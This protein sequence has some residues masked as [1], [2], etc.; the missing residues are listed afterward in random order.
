MP[1]FILSTCG[2]SLFTNGISNEL[3]S[4][5]FQYANK[6]DWSEIPQD[7]VLRL[8]QYAELQKQKLLQAD[9]SL[10]KK[11]SAELNSLLSWQKDQRF[12]Q[13]DMRVLLAT[14]TVL[15]QTTA[16]MIQEWL[17]AQG[18]NAV[19]MSASGL[20]TASLQS[21]RESLSELTANLIEQVT[22]FKENGYH[23]I[24]N[25]AGGFKSLNGFLQAFSTIY[26]DETF[27]IFESSSEVLSIPKLPFRLDA[28]QI[29]KENLH[30]FRRLAYQLPVNKT[31]AYAIP[32]TLLFSIGSD[33]ILSEW[34]ELL[35]QSS[36]KDLYKTQ[37]LPSISERIVFDKLF[38][39][40]TKQLDPLILK[41]VN[42]RIAELTVYVEGD[43][44]SALK[45]VDP[46][47][48]QEKQCKV[49]NLWECDLD[50]HHRIFMVKDGYTFTLQYVSSALH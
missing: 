32:E 39:N 7:A 43:C 3:R 14:D 25:L 42:D 33:I 2:T 34:G 15:G 45:S 37:L 12:D 18:N 4:E 36:Y 24:F 35:W 48:L 17:K 49:K 44:R 21:F 20:N 38:E 23:I 47:P 27:Y 46:K 10:V 1:N 30:I 11:L 31:E 6:K 8:Q 26:A 13:Q 50:A 9:L 28:E 5:F 22:N 19:I 29:I 40:S 41:I 16:T